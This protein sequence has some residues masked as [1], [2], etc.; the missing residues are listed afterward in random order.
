MQHHPYRVRPA[1]LPKAV[2]DALDRLD[3]AHARAEEARKAAR[4]LNAP[5]AL[6]RAQEADKT[7]AVEAVAKGKAVPDAKHVD[8]LHADREKAARAAEAHDQHLA[9]CLRAVD[10]ARWA[11]WDAEREAEQT[12]RAAAVA[13]L[14]EQA[15]GLGRA[16]EAEH[17]ARARAEWLRT[18]QMQPGRAEIYA[19]DAVPLLLGRGIGPGDGLPPREYADSAAAVIARTAVAPFITEES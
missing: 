7:A 6:R 13:A 16:V 10:T 12:R 3:D 14:Q 9:D 18:G 11:A 1:D 8:T 17:A 4:A 2:A 15:A 19:W 5:D